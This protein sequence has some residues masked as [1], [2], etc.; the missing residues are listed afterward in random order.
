VPGIDHDAH[1]AVRH[2]VHSFST[3]LSIDP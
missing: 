2:I 3:R 1:I